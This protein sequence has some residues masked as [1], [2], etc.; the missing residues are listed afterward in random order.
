MCLVHTLGERHLRQEGRRP[1]L[2]IPRWRGVGAAAPAP[3]EAG[4][5]ASICAHG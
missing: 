4:Y 3:G 5:S 2:R 1:L